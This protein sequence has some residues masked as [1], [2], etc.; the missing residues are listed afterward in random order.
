MRQMGIAA[1]VF[2]LLLA[3]LNFYA[4]IYDAPPDT[5][6]FFDRNGEAI[7]TINPSYDGFQIWTPVDRIPKTIVETFVK[8]EDRFFYWHHG[9]NPVALIK[10]AIENLAGGKVRRGGSTIT[11]QLA[12]NLIQEKKGRFSARSWTNKLCETL[13]ALGLEL[14]HSKKWILERYLNSIYFGRRTYGVSAAADV[15]FGKELRE[16][17]SAE[18]EFLAGLPKGPNRLN[19]PQPPFFKGGGSDSPPLKG[20]QGEF[21]VARHF[22]EWVATRQAAKQLPAGPIVH[23]TLDLNLQKRLETAV[24]ALL[25]E[26]AGEDPLLTASAVVIDVP[27]GGIL[28]MVGSRDYDND[29]IKGQVNGA[30]ALRQPGSTLKPFTYFAAFSKGF[31]P[32][33]VITD[34]PRS[35]LA[36]TAAD[37]E[38]YIPQNFDRRFHGD[39]TIREA[40]GNSYNV[41]AV[42]TLNE[43][44]LSYY[45][46]I[47]KKFGFTS[48][49]KPPM[50][51]GLAV[52]LGAGEVSLLEL[53][54]AYAVL[55]RGGIFLPYQWRPGQPLSE[56]TSIIN[57]AKQYAAQVTDILTDPSARLKAFGFNED[58]AIDG[59]PVAVKTGTSYN[60]RDNWTVGYTPQ[61]AVG[62]WVGH[63]DG[64]PLLGTTGA[65][66]AGPVWHAVVENVVREWRTGPVACGFPARPR[67]RCGLLGVERRDGLSHTPHLRL[68]RDREPSLRRHPFAVLDT[69]PDSDPGWRVRSPLPHARFRLHPYLPAEHQKILAE[70][71]VTDPEIESLRCYLDGK[72]VSETPILDNTNLRF[73]VPPETG[74]HLL[75]IKAPDGRKQTIPFY[76]METT[77]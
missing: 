60:H 37:A 49:K 23:T 4:R 16:L 18:I 20:G 76:I 48:L 19:P 3:F 62:V 8:T 6:T 55:A 10:A 52:T 33:T 77:T 50:Y 21:A 70:V 43:I 29:A 28:A 68:R 61:V 9:V 36:L 45:H 13:L 2:L 41:P 7:G 44:G 42:A 11:Q 24:Q 39:V 26:R 64:S 73:W 35:F 34:E 15:Y 32:S 63:A 27:T 14:R 51:Y 1:F 38:A 47:L 57:N 74:D 22:I 30:I 54:N 69:Q 59:F 5:K 17:N 31:S 46:D 40:L 71:E 72:L 65:T 58:L 66:G 75:T 67:R 25:E 56:Q 12:K 53:T